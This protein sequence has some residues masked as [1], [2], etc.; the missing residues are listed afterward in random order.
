MHKAA[1]LDFA[2]VVGG[3]S[4][5]FPSW[6]SEFKGHS[7]WNFRPGIQKLWLP[8]S[9]LLLSAHSH[10]CTEV[11]TCA[12]LSATISCLILA[13]SFTTEGLKG[14]LRFLTTF[15]F[16][17]YGMWW[18]WQKK[19]RQGKKEVF[20]E[21][22]RVS[23]KPPDE[24]KLSEPKLTDLNIHHSLQADFLFNLNN[25]SYH[26]CGYLPLGYLPGWGLQALRYSVYI[27]ALWYCSVH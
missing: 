23:Y 20:R 11:R 5:D 6:N 7:S 26:T 15:W 4:S 19:V 14:W 22:K 9:H 16:L 24:P 3:I 10:Q 18:H 13:K 8:N 21:I 1:V 25:S 12:L 17:K 27:Q 2:V